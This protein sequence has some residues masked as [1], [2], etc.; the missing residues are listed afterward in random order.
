MSKFSDEERAAIMAEA[1]RNLAWCREIERDRI[2]RLAELPPVEDKLVRYKREQNELIA[3]RA[4]AREREEHQQRIERRRREHHADIDARI[5]AHIIE[6]Y[7]NVATAIDKLVD[8][9][10]RKMGDMENT[11]QA[12]LKDL[13]T[14]LLAKIETTLRSTP[15]REPL[16][17]P[18]LRSMRRDVN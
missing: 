7:E 2:R 4:R 15:E 16:E 1:R 11:R 12:A 5:N 10:L 18:P 6:V 14:E 17:L 3:E 8:E 9:I 13:K